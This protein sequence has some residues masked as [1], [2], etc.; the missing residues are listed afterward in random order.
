[1][2]INLAGKLDLWSHI[3]LGLVLTLLGRRGPHLHTLWE[4]SVLMGQYKF[5]VPP[6]LE[7]FSA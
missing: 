6:V 3:H 5:S 7:N 2:L 4:R 1:M